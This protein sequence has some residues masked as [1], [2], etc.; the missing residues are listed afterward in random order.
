[1]VLPYHPGRRG[2]INPSAGSPLKVPSRNDTEDRLRK[3]TQNNG[4]SNRMS[5]ATKA[6]QQKENDKKME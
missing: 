5:P 4:F 6:R 2:A 1:V 3:N